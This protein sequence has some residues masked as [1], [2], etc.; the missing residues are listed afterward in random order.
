MNRLSSAAPAHAQEPGDGLLPEPPRAN[1]ATPEPMSGDRRRTLRQHQDVARGIH[2]L[3]GGPLTTVPD[4]T[5]GTCKHLRRRD[6]W[7][8]CGLI[9][10]TG[11]PGTDARRWW[12]GCLKWEPRTQASDG[13]P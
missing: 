8:K 11:G 5:C 9:P 10:I 1:T 3:A 6:R 12:P 4:A 7:L 13:V 2:P